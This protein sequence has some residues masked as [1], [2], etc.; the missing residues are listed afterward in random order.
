MRIVY[1]VLGI[2]FIFVGALGGLMPVLPGFPFFFMGIVCFMRASCRFR[3]AV[4]STR[5]YKRFFA[6]YE[7]NGNIPTGRLILMGIAAFFIILIFGSLLLGIFHYLQQN[8]DVLPRLLSLFRQK[9]G[10]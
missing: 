3:K 10:L 9:L 8:G 2:I 4:K 5:V 6:K 1:I 7:V